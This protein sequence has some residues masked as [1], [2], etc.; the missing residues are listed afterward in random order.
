MAVVTGVS[1][2]RN[3]LKSGQ[4]FLR[5]PCI[6][7]ELQKLYRLCRNPLNSGQCFLHCYQAGIM[8][9][10]YPGRNPLKSGQCFLHITVVSIGE[11][12]YY[13][14]IPSKSGQCF[15]RFKLVDLVDPDTMDVAIPSTRVNVSYRKIY[16]GATQT[17]W[18][19]KCRNPLKSGQCFLQHPS[20][21]TDYRKLNTPFSGTPL[22]L[23]FLFPY[24]TYLL[25]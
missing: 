5:E 25:H 21:L 16:I 23:C 6:T 7:L 3:P 22:F 8:F 10:W 20:F 19:P 1:R 15:L 2:S 14:A 12:N 4:C 9:T 13:V 17:W 11:G 18:C 24:L